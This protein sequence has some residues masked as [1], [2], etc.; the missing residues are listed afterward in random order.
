MPPMLVPCP[1]MNLVA[2]WMTMSAP[3]LIGLTRY[4]L[5]HGVVDD[6]RHAGVVRDLGDRLDIERDQVRIADCLGVDRLGLRRDRR[7]DSLGVSGSTKLTL[8][9][10]F[11]SV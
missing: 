2:E 9:P 6:Q 1:P 7:C 3:C 10:I 5:R 11:G 8:M 4:G